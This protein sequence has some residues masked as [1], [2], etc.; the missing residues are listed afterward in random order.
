MTADEAQAFGLID[1]VE[2]KRAEP[3]ARHEM[4]GGPARSEVVSCSV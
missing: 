4:S 2:T 3:A 1:R